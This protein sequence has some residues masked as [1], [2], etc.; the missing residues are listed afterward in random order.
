MKKLS[1]IVVACLYFAAAIGQ[2]EKIVIAVL[3]FVT[4]IQGVNPDLVQE[5][6]TKQ[7]VKSGRFDN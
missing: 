7:F 1:L 4:N 6:V 3:P 2:S 5:M